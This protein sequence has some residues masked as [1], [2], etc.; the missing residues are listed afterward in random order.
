ML[1]NIE[2]GTS[3]LDSFDDGMAVVVG[4]FLPSPGYEAVAYLFRRITDAIESRTPV[5]ELLSRRDMLDLRL[6][7]PDGTRIPVEFM[8]VYDFGDDLDREL[9]VKLADVESWHRARCRAE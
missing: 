8:T 1:G 3:H 7:G 9:E 4:V 5:T 2:V 6:L